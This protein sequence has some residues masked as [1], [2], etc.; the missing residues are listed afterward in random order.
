MKTGVTQNKV[1]PLIMICAKKEKNTQMKMETSTLD[2]GRVTSNMAKESKYGT[3]VKFT[4]A[5]GR[6]TI[7][8]KEP[9]GMSAENISIQVDTN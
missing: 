6:I 9:L 5:L 4:K 7:N 1:I 2:S 3:T 8:E